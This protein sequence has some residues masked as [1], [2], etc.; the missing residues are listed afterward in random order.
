MRERRE[1]E[2]LLLQ[3]IA[4]STFTQNRGS[5]P[6]AAAEVNGLRI[7]SVRASSNAMSAPAKVEECSPPIPKRKSRFTVAKYVPILGWL[8][9]YTRLDAVS[10]LI[11]GITLGLTMIPQSIAYAAL[12]G[13]TAQVYHDW[14]LR[15]LRTIRIEI[16]TDKVFKLIMR[17]SL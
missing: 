10:D 8:P 9:R 5:R 2:K 12:A 7:W 4:W 15:N 14:L 6:L 11:A 16:R 13:L 3:I 17:I 1:R